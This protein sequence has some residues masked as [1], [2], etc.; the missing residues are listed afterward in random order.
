MNLECSL[1]KKEDIYVNTIVTRLM[2]IEHTPTINSFYLLGFEFMS[3]MYT[4]N[5]LNQITNIS[6][7]SY[8]LTIVCFIAS[9]LY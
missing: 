6:Y 7:S 5:C 4:V 2:W 1:H 3:H 8:Y 9:F